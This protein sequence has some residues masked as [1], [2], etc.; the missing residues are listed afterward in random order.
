MEFDQ[1]SLG[2]NGEGGLKRPAPNSDHH[3]RGNSVGG[4]R[5]REYNKADPPD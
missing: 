1:A 4:R 2:R 5:P 3:F